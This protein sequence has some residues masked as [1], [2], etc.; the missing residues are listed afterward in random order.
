MRFRILASV[1]VVPLAMSSL[2]A[3][4]DTTPSTDAY[5]ASTP[6]VIRQDAL[7]ATAAW[8]SVHV[9]NEAQSNGL[10][11]VLEES[12]DN[13]GNCDGTRT[14]G[15][16]ST[17]RIVQ[18]G[19]TTY[20][21]GS[22]NYWAS[23]GLNSKGVSAVADTWVTG[24]L[25]DVIGDFCSLS[26]WSG[27][28]ADH[29]NA[30]EDLTVEGTETIDGLE[31]VKLVVKEEDQSNTFFIATSAPHNVVKVLDNSGA[32]SIEFS[33]FNE[34]VKVTAPP[35]ALPFDQFRTSEYLQSASTQGNGR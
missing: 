18:V 32:G 14:R 9:K 17:D 12:L 34:P 27:V 4:G 16:T 33:Q 5:A 11:V 24:K 23:R 7:T 2:T 20:V 1:L 22:V 21:K 3:C 15:T 19:G 28:V 30:T 25:D 6:Q 10:G 26:K 8:T 31:V 35:Y 13:A 29:L